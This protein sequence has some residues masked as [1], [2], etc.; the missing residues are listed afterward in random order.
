M[1]EALRFGT[2][3]AQKAKR[4]SGSESP[5]RN[6]VRKSTMFVFNPVATYH[7]LDNISQLVFT[8]GC[9]YYST[10]VRLFIK[11]HYTLVDYSSLVQVLCLLSFVPL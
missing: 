5:H 3:L 11:T 4:A 2:S 7:R 6:S 1:Y 10:S 8:E 9:I